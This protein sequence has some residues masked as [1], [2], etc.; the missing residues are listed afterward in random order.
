MPNLFRRPTIMAT[1]IAV[2]VM[3]VVN[4]FHISDSPIMALIVF[5]IAFFALFSAFMA[6]AERQ[7]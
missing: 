5:A 3:A 2:V 4:F 1:L 7:E 6:W